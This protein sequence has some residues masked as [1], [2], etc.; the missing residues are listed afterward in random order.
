S[1]VAAA[2]ARRLAR[3]FLVLRA[4]ADPADFRLPRAAL[5]GLDKEGRAAVL[6][7]LRALIA[8]PHELPSLMRLALHTRR[9]LAALKRAAP[10]FRR[11]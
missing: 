1:G 6:P 10:E 3:P 5:V 2:A 9:A 4:I 11:D 8:A 7:V